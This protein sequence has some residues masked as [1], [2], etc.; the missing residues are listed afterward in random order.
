VLHKG[1]YS[2]ELCNENLTLDQATRSKDEFVKF[3]EDTVKAVMDIENTRRCDH[4]SS[5]QV[6]CRVDIG[7]LQTRSGGDFLYYISELERSLTVGLYCQVTA[8]ST[9]T[10]INSAVQLMLH[11]IHTSRVVGR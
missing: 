3:V 2:T 11:Y 10:M 4:S 6:F 7:V 1:G 8:A 9:W 5:L